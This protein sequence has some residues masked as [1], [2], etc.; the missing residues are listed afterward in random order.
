MCVSA[1]T[2]ESLGDLA[3]SEEELESIVLY[4]LHY[5]VIRVVKSLSFPCFL[6]VRV[7]SYTCSRGQ[8][9]PRYLLEALFSCDFAHA[10]EN[11]RPKFHLRISLIYLALKRP[12]YQ[13]SEY[14]LIL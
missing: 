14:S 9:T 4:L 1:N 12:V 11:K 7:S 8:L 3:F 13:N 6:P 2:T 10:H 5:G